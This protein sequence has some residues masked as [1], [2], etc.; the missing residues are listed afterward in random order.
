MQHVA[1]RRSDEIA[2]ANRLIGELIDIAALSL[3]FLEVAVDDP[4]YKVGAVS[5]LVARIR[6]VLDEH[7]GRYP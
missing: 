3:P 2:V 5:P 1:H 4:A 7:G 6:K